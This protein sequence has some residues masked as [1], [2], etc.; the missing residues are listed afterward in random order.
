VQNASRQPIY[1]VL[2]VVRDH[3]GSDFSIDTV[4]MMEVLPP[5]TIETFDG[6]FD[7]TTSLASVNHRLYMTFRDGRGLSWQRAT[8]GRLE[9][10]RRPVDDAP[11]AGRTGRI[12]RG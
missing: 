4:G 7:M 2:F 12:P 1:D 11:G 10:A 5:D 6:A 3:N 9:P 8:H